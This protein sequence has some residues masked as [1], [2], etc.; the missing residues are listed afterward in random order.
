MSSAQQGCSMQPVLTR[1]QACRGR[2]TRS[3]EGSL[4]A[5]AVKW[6]PLFAAVC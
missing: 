6:L 1:V 2:K 5:L 3:A 4:G